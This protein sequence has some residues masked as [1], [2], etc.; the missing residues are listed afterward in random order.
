M[1]KLAQLC[2]YRQFKST[3]QTEKYLYIFIKNH[4][5]ALACFRQSSHNL[6]VEKGRWRRKLIEGKWHNHKIP[7]EERLCIFCPSGHVESESHVLMLCNRY[8]DLRSN[9]FHVAKPLIANIDN[10]DVNSRFIEIIIAT[11]TAKRQTEG[12]MSCVR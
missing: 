12:R 8:S 1:F 3:F 9:I 5:Q 6:E 2:T 10:L 7:V 4:R 11:D